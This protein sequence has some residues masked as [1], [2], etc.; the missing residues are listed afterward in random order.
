M[1]RTNANK[2]SLLIE[3]FIKE[4]GLA[5]GLERVRIFRAWDLVVG[6]TVAKAT[7]NKFFKDGVLYCTINSSI[8]RTHL[9]Y[10]KEDIL[11]KL[12]K[13]LQSDIINK[14]VLK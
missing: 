4:Q 9:Y 1:Q 13:M 10:N 3:Q 6:E 12:N 2:I 14:I 8:I 7:S 5:E 11:A